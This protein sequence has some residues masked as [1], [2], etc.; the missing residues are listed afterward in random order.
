MI[1][2]KSRHVMDSTSNGGVGNVYEDSF[3]M[4]YWG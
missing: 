2:L 4:I 1:N 3:R